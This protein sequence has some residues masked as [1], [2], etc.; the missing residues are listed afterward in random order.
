MK[1]IKIGNYR[2]HFTDSVLKVM[3]KYKQAHPKS[4]EA[5]G[6]L[7]GQVKDKDAYVMRASI[8]TAWDRATRTSFHRNKEIAQIIIDFEFANSDNKTIYLGEWHTHPEKQPSPS[9]TDRKMIEDQYHNNDLNEPF[10][11]QFILGIRGLYVG[12]IDSDDF[13]EFSAKS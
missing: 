10:L 12:L 4:L 3:E 13:H 9:P 1:V 7:L 2:L 5:G 11:I 6:I 8:P